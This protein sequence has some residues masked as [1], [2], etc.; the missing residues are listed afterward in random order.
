LG[1]DV[2]G[3]V[4]GRGVALAG[5]GSADAEQAADL[6]P[7][8]PG[9]SGGLDLFGDPHVGL[10]D[11]AGEQVQLDET[12]EHGHEPTVGEVDDGAVDDDDGVEIDPGAGRGGIAQVGQ[13]F[14]DPHLAPGLSTGG[15]AGF[16]FVARLAARR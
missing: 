12:V 5:D 16:D 15:G 3:V 13:I 8:G 7:G 14:H 1:S 2:T 10:G 4:A 9:L 11:D 6:G